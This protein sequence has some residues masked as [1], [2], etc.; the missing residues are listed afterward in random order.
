MYSR[1]DKLTGSF[2][3]IP[4]FIAADQPVNSESKIPTPFKLF[5]HYNSR[6]R[7]ALALH[8]SPNSKVSFFTWSCGDIKA[9]FHKI[10]SWPRD[11]ERECIFLEAMTNNHA[12]ILNQHP[13]SQP[14]SES[15]KPIERSDKFIKDLREPVQITKPKRKNSKKSPA[16]MWCIRLKNRADQLYLKDIAHVGAPLQITMR[17]CGNSDLHSNISRHAETLNSAAAVHSPRHNTCMAR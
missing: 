12:V 13:M 14:P 7:L 15:R 10:T 9:C 5:P 1:L 6:K 16:P 11:V 8:N 3:S 2:Y 17:S 4:D